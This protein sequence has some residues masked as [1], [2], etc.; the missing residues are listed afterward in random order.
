MLMKGLSP[1]IATILLIAFTVAVA[2]IMSVWISGFSTQTTQTVG[3]KA[4]YEITCSYGAMT[5][6]NLKYQEPRLSGIVTNHGQI[7]IGNLT[8]S[9]IYSNAT[10]Q[11]IELCT[12]GGNGVSCGVSN[13]SLI[14]G[15][16]AAFNVTIMG[17][18][19][20]TIRLASN[21][22]NVV[23]TAERGDVA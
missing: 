6:Q 21:C 13:M 12:S 1:M 17:S 22:S 3:D 7:A 2:G 4:S 9:I 5:M 16:Q 23:S 11:R 8:L 18:N 20:Q 10:F 14:V 19:Y 15:E